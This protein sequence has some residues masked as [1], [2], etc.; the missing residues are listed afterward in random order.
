MHS[1]LS[2]MLVQVVHL[3]VSLVDI[4]FFLRH[5]SLGKHLF[6]VI[7]LQARLHEKNYYSFHC[8]SLA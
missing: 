1:L 7:L 2:E 6:Q 5:G 8:V 3:I 4:P